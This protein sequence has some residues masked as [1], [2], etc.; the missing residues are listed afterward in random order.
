MSAIASDFDHD[1]VDDANDNCAEVSNIAQRDTDSDGY[2]NR[3]DPDFDNNLQV[4]GS[5]ANYLLSVFYS[6]DPKADLD[7][8]GHVDFRDMA[9]LGRHY[10]ELRGVSP[11][12][13]QPAARYGGPT[14]SIFTQPTGIRGEPGSEIA[15]EIVWDFHENATIGG[16]FDVSYDEDKLEFVSWEAE[17]VGDP[18][19]G[20][21]PDQL[22]G[23]LSG[24]AFGE[25]VVGITGPHVVGT[26]TMEVID[27]GNSTI[28]LADTQS[29][30]G[31]FVTIDT[32]QVIPIDYSGTVVNGPVPKQPTISTDSF[33]LDQGAVVVNTSTT[34]E[35]TVTNIGNSDLLLGSVGVKD[36]LAPPFSF[37]AEGC[38]SQTLAPGKS[39]GIT[40]AF[41]PTNATAFTDSFDIPSNDPVRPLLSVTMAGVATLDNEPNLVIPAYDHPIFLGAI[42]PGQSRNGSFSVHNRGTANLVIGSIGDKDELN[43]PLSFR[44]DNCSGVTLAP[45]ENCGVGVRF[46]YAP[47]EF[48][49]TFN[50][51]SNDPDTPQFI[52][53][54][55]AEG[56][57]PP[58]LDV[59]GTTQG[60]GDS[61]FLDCT[62]R[63]TGE[64]VAAV[65]STSK[66][67]SCRGTGLTISD[68]DEIGV[69]LNGRAEAAGVDQ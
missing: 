11:S 41:A 59:S 9:I 58:S 64:R 24:I 15:L 34:A 6:A 30:G 50:I 28:T 38:S 61:I 3:C 54:V 20:R 66:P 63:T 7:G 37:V 44:F 25:F 27:S 29:V 14:G 62:N 68:G 18:G 26:L 10:G 42:S 52:A 2:G 5:D 12:A 47:G 21:E 48:V 23:L 57:P 49:D 35:M 45:L 67:W 32:F 39:C 22:T 31:P 60:V 43:P 33:V 1:G 13:I 16:G 4:D 40:V 46:D 69:L 19:F 55:L 56:L 53:T 51:P 36:A 65:V 8:D 17:P